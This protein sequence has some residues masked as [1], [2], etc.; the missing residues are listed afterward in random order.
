MKYLVKNNKVVI[1]LYTLI[2]LTLIYYLLN[3]GKIQIHVYLNQLVGNKIIDNFF[4]YITYLGDGRVA[5]ILLLCILLYN[6]RLGICSIASFLTA[7][8]ASSILK[9]LFFDE[10]MRP[11]H[12]FQWTVHIPIKW[13]ENTDLHTHNS[14][15]SGHSTQVFAIFICLAFFANKNINKLLFLALAVLTAFSRVYLS[16]HWLVDITVGSIIGM[17]TSLVLYYF[18]ISRNKLQKLNKPLLKLKKSE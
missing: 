17:T 16:Q 4:T 10:V 2:V 9:Y 6:V 13:I 11:W 5:P 3:Y 1:A 7:T 18:F 8:L 14:F 15:P 12:V